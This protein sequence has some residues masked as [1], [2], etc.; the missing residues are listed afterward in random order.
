M[1]LQRTTKTTETGMKRITKTITI[2]AGGCRARAREL[3]LRGIASLAVVAG[4]QF[5][6]HE[7]DL[8]LL[9]F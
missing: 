9:Q 1:R 8:W 2:E 3:M 7:E 5:L 4:T 6:Y